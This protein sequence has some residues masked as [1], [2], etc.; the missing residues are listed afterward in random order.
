VRDHS[1][2]LIDGLCGQGSRFSLRRMSVRQILNRVMHVHPRT[3]GFRGP[4][5]V[6]TIERVMQCIDAPSWAHHGAPLVQCRSRDHACKKSGTGSAVVEDR[7]DLRI[8]PRPRSARPS[9]QIPTD[10]CHRGRV[11]RGKAREQLRVLGQLREGP[12][13]LR[14]HLLDECRP[15]APPR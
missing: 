3:F 13:G 15:A 10:F 8:L 1:G 2:G 6:P 9:L 7:S 12:E 11:V 14:L 4:C 5:N